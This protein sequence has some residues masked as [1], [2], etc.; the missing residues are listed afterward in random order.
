M[1]L[2]ETPTLGP[3]L[4]DA[5]E[6]AAVGH[7][8]HGPNRLGRAYV[9]AG[10]DERV[11]QHC[12]RRDVVGRRLQA[13]GAVGLANHHD[14]RVPEAA[15]WNATPQCCDPPSQVPEAAAWNATP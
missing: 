12:A 11:A 1:L 2:D 4:A 13:K 6:V 9:R 8:S 5:H 15:A 10:L 3:I 7:V 14:G